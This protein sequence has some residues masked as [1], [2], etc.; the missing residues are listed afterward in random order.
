MLIV[1]HDEGRS[2]IVVKGNLDPFA[3]SALQ[4]EL[5]GA[6]HDGAGR[7]VVSLERC[8]RLCDAALGVLLDAKA[9]FASRFTVIPPRREGGRQ[10]LRERGIVAA[11]A[12]ARSVAH[13][14][15]S[16]AA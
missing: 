1:E 9:Q 3:A 6:R 5:T 14:R 8:S 15:A 13:M 10:R 12:Y 16:R 7:V 11:T 4:A 2:V